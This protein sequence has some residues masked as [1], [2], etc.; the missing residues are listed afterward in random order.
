M[1]FNSI[2]Q[3][4]AEPWQKEDT[5]ATSL[6]EKSE[7]LKFWHTRVQHREKVEEQIKG[8]SAPSKSLATWNIYDPVLTVLSFPC[9]SFILRQ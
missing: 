6:K 3:N 5:D 7:H 2:K 8:N 1:V 4:K 9:K